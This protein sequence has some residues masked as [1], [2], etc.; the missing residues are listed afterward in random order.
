MPRALPA[1][2]GSPVWGA[3]L[4]DA[5]ASLP[6]VAALNWLPNSTATVDS[7]VPIRGAFVTG[8][9]AA[10]R[11]TNPSAAGLRTRFLGGVIAAVTGLLTS[12]AVTTWTLSQ[13]HIVVFTL[14]FV[15]VVAPV[16][17]LGFGRLG[18]WAANAVAA[19]LTSG[20]D[21]R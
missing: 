5:L 16:F 19:R 2:R 6:A 4:F 13:V 20:G 17:G 8:A 21:L 15:L 14:G 10:V 18:G 7:G 12:G 9:T 11:S 1:P 3:T